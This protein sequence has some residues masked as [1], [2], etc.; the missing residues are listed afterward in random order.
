MQKTL[1][2]F[3]YTKKLLSCHFIRNQI[4]DLN[5]VIGILQFNT[6]ASVLTLLILNM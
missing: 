5:T 3:K 2:A 4:G 6:N 1:L